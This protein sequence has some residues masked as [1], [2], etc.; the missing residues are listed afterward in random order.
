MSSP[1]ITP[2]TES[3]PDHDYPV[4][5]KVVKWVHRSASGAKLV[6]DQG[7]NHSSAWIGGDPRHSESKNRHNALHH[8]AFGRYVA[9]GV[10]R[11]AMQPAGCLQTAYRR[12]HCS[13]R[14]LDK[15]LRKKIWNGLRSIASSKRSKR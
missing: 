12:S 3:L 7:W 2:I 9:D 5:Y 4:V 11:T 1:D 6:V 10:Y 14:S 15:R 13:R 8:S